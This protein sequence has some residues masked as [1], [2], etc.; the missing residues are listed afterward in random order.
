MRVLIST[1]EILN[2]RKEA[3]YYVRVE[4]AFRDKVF[5]VS[6][7]IPKNH[8]LIDDVLWAP[9][10]AKIVKLNYDFFEDFLLK[11]DIRVEDLQQ[12]LEDATSSKEAFENILREYSDY[13]FDY[14]VKEIYRLDFDGV[15]IYLLRKR[16][17][18]ASSL[19]ERRAKME[20]LKE[21]LQNGYFDDKDIPA[22]Q[23]I[24]EYAE[25][26]VPFDTTTDE[27]N[28]PLN[29]FVLINEEDAKKIVEEALERNWKW[30]EYPPVKTKRFS[31]GDL[32]TTSTLDHR[33]LYLSPYFRELVYRTR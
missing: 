14:L 2:Q 9:L 5:T 6:V 1:P 20:E 13:L 7:L 29:K 21:E 26:K 30:R 8:K 15:N 32:P 23:I 18:K 3:R 19:K 4:G 28:K 16:R 12:V 17:V 33:V 22:L 31:N 10:E 24:S 25:Y 27:N 11:E